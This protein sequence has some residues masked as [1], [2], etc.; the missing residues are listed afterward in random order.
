MRIAHLSDLHLCSNF[1]KSNVARI[2]EL[3]EHALAK[4]AQHFVFTGDITDNAEEK[5]YLS[6][7]ELLKS[8]NLLH[9]DKS[10]I[11]I[12]NHDIFGGPQTAHDVVNFPFKC[13]NANYNSRVAKFVYHFRELFENTIRP[14]NE[15][16]FPF[17]KELKNVLLV[18]L[19]SIDE[20]SRFK[21]P[22]ASNGKISKT[23]RKIAANFLSMPKFKEKVKIVLVHHHFY[24]KS[25][26]SK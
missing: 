1:R 8:F 3:I 20:Y 12:G 21:N 6:F 2:K 15:V 26:E 5:E 13:M 7:R 9:S 4:G 17:A 18:G 10:S 14:H 16:F 19:N 25:E 23:N 11:V 22:F 24:L